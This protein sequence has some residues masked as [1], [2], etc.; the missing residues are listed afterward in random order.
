MKNKLTFRLRIICLLLACMFTLSCSLFNGNDDETLLPVFIQFDSSC[1]YENLIPGDV[2][3]EIEMESF[4][5]IGTDATKNTIISLREESCVIRTFRPQDLKSVIEDLQ[6]DF[7]TDRDSQF[8]ELKMKRG[9]EEHDVLSKEELRELLEDKHPE[10]TLP[11]GIISPYQLYVTPEADAVVSLADQLDGIQEIYNEALSW[12]WISEEYLNGVAEKWYYPEEFLTDTPSLA[13]NPS[14]GDIASDCSEQANTLVSLLIADGWDPEDVRVVLGLVDFQGTSGGHAWVEINE[15]GQW[16]AL[17]AT[18]GAYY[19]E[20]TNTL[21]D[22]THIPYK[23]F[24]YATYPVEEVWYYYN[25]IYFWDETI[26]AGNAPVSWRQDSA[27]AWQE[28]LENF[29]GQQ[30]QGKVN[31]KG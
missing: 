31:V 29:Q 7:D 8:E 10:Q 17:E 5:L 6:N 26:E 12:I 13:N 25:N 24:K 18:S 27:P 28:E 11:G 20:S 15:N 14:P 4:V 23:Y 21:V 30:G 19:D 3:K 22:A 9:L 1:E 2:R 16:F